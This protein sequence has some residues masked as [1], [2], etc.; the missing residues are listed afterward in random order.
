MFLLLPAA[1]AADVISG[2][3][4]TSGYGEGYYTSYSFINY[5]PLCGAYGTLETYVKGVNEITCT[6]CDAD[7]SYS[8][9]DKWEGGERAWLTT[10]Y[11]P[12]PTTTSAEIAPV[13]TAPPEP[14]KTPIEIYQ[15]LLSTYRII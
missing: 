7:Y 15:S 6:R 3:G 13:Q 14:A 1:S 2:S 12:E 8:G 4:Y 11:E 10:Y 5:C 9:R